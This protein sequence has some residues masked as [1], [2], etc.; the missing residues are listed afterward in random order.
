MTKS[1]RADNIILQYSVLY[2]TKWTQRDRGERVGVRDEPTEDLSQDLAEPYKCTLRLEL[3]DLS[4]Q[5]SEYMLIFLCGGQ[6]C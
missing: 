4:G 6:M 2:M 1:D 3:H 5:S